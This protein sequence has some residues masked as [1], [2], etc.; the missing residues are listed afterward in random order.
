MKPEQRPYPDRDRSVSEMILNRVKAA[1]FIYLKLNTILSS[2]IPIIFVLVLFLFKD[3]KA[4]PVSQEA[5]KQ[6]ESGQNYLGQ[7]YLAEIIRAKIIQRDLR[8]PKPSLQA[9]YLNRS[10]C[11]SGSVQ[12]SSSWPERL[13]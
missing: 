12:A 2:G 4:L 9:I 5:K 7:N 10:R 13:E 11:F 8:M 6:N 3:K 1:S